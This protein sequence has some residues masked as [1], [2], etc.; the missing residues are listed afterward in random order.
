MAQTSSPT[1]NRGFGPA[2]PLSTLN[3]DMTEQEKEQ[4]QQTLAQQKEQLLIQLHQARLEYYAVERQRTK[5]SH[6]LNRLQRDFDQLTNYIKQQK[7]TTK[8]PDDYYSS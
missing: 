3:T 4:L 8:T 1:K 2:K 6:N 7:L 5:A